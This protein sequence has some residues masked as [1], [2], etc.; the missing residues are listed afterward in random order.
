VESIDR[1]P[2][3]S[4][5]FPEGMMSL[6]EA[7]NANRLFDRLE[8]L[9][10]TGVELLPDASAVV[11]TEAERRRVS[12]YLIQDNVIDDQ[13][14]WVFEDK[15]TIDLMRGSLVHPNLDFVLVTI[16]NEKIAADPG[17]EV[18]LVDGEDPFR[19]RLQ[20]LDTNS[21]QR[22]R[23]VEFN[24][25]EELSINRGKPWFSTDGSIL[26]LPLHATDCAPDPNWIGFALLDT[27][28]WTEIARWDF[29]AASMTEDM[30]MLL[31]DNFGGPA[32]IL[33]FPAL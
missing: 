9:A 29:G 6:R 22:L 2:A 23:T 19:S 18:V 14:V 31:V 13:P 28:T 33:S 27:S 5:V 20:L 10:A 30:T 12:K 24:D 21:G 16:G 26:G 11:V 32:D 4:G 3:G 17:P 25:C 1:A 15:T 8:L 7:V